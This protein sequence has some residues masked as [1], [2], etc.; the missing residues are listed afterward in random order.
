[1]DDPAGLVAAAAS[2]D[3]V[4]LL[5]A[6]R[7]KLAADLVGCGGHGSAALARELRA[8]A[9][10]LSSLGARDGDDVDE[11]AAQRAA[12]RARLAGGA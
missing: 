9:E 12:R 2:G 8:T 11:I 6:L 7:D 5:K 1:M 10:E 4:Q 3:R